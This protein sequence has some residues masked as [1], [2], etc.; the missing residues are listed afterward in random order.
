MKD[1]DQKLKEL[2]EEEEKEKDLLK[3]KEQVESKPDKEEKKEIKVET[4]KPKEEKIDDFLFDDDEDDILDVPLSVYSQPRPIVQS[5]PQEI[6]VEHKP[7]DNP[8]PTIKTE[9]PKQDF[10]PDELLFDDDIE[11]ETE[12]PKI[13]VDNDSIIVKDNNLISDDE[14]FDDFFDE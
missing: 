14:F 13:N 4:T 12:K 9:V 5:K 3:Q 6:K 10:D 1:I 7:V 11:L 8:K 2:D